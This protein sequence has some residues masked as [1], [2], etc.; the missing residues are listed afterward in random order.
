[1]KCY[2]VE[3]S[4][5]LK[6]IKAYFEMEA[7][8]TGGVDNWEYYGQSCTEYL[9][10]MKNYFGLTDEEKEEFDF[11]LM[12]EKDLEDEFEVIAE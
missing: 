8:E 3:E 1:M 9:E 4:T 6:L 7:L 2:K 5:L 11:D 12:A 10:D